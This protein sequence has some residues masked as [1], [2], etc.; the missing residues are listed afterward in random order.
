MLN[1]ARIVGWLGAQAGSVPRP[2]LYNNASTCI[3][4]SYET[5]RSPSHDTR[6]RCAVARSC[7]SCFSCFSYLERAWL[8]WPG[9][10]HR[11]ARLS[12]AIAI[13]SVSGRSLYSRRRFARTQ[14]SCPSPNQQP[15]PSSPASPLQ[16]FGPL[17][18]PTKEKQP[19]AVPR[20][21]VHH[22]PLIPFPDSLALVITLNAGSNHGG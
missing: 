4:P 8:A 22:R 20:A 7:F 11:I 16:D 14:N 18:P 3:T 2:R 13:P 17:P 5:H 9:V 21:S 12:L 19:G 15:A 10:R 6:H 1:A